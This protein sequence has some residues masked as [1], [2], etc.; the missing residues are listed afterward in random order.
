[1]VCLGNICRSPL[2][3]GLLRHHL[4]QAHLDN[5]IEVDSAGTSNYHIGEPPD[6]RTQKNA[7]K[8]G[9]DL[10]GLRG[11]QFSIEDL[12]HFD[13]IYVMDTNNFN[14]AHAIAEQATGKAEIDFLLNILWPNENRAV[15]DP[16]YGSE[17]DFEQV[18]Q[19]VDAACRQLVADLKKTD[20]K[21]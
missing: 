10:S 18:F 2:A 20:Q 11:R 21:R 16:Y 1:M 13:R 14:A 5:L 19:L 8:H 6:L 15:P 4:Q 17:K 3:E 9:V 7:A 12:N